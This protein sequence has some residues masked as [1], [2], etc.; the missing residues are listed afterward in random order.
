MSNGIIF[1]WYILNLMFKEGIFDKNQNL[2]NEMGDV[3]SFFRGG[4]MPISINT[5]FFLEI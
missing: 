3:H 5:S 4:K 2:K 1:F